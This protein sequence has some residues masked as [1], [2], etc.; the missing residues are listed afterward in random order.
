MDEQ[1]VLIEAYTDHFQRAINYPETVN[2]EDLNDLKTSALKQ[3][4]PVRKKDWRLS[5]R[6]SPRL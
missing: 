3:R 6:H 4:A 1:L 5:A 2:D